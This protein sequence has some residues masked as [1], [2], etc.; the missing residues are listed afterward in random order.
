MDIPADVHIHSTLQSGCVYYYEENSPE[1][2]SAE[3]HYFVVLNKDP[4]TDALLILVCAS[5]QIQKRKNWVEDMG[6]PE[7]TLVFISPDHYQGFSKDTVIDCNTIFQ[8]TIDDI[9]EKRRE[10]KLRVC[11]EIMPQEIVKQLR[12]GVIA[13]PRIARSYK[14]LLAETDNT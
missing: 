1:F 14:K 8:K 12:Q 13:S 11:P 7:E 6:Y 5:S 9:I 10:T 4:I 2:L 3:P